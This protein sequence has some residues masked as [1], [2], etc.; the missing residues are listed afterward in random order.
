M[1]LS[2]EA[3]AERY[4]I[5]LQALSEVAKAYHFQGRLDEAFHL[6]Q[7][8]MQLLS[9][10]EVQPTDRVKFL[11][12]Y[13]GF[14]IDN[15]FL[16]NHEEDLML[17]VVQ[18][19]REEAEAAQDQ[20]A[21]ASTLYQVGQTLYY[22]HMQANENDYTDARDYFQQA[23][24]LREK[25][26]DLYGLANS[27]FYT[28]LTYERHEQEEPAVDYYQ[29]A[30]PL[31]EQHGNWRAASE[32]A[33]HLAGLSLSK[34]NEHSLRY[35]LKSLALREEM[36]FN[37]GLPPAQLLVSDVYLTV[38]DLARALD[39]CQQSEQ[40][41]QEMGLQVYLM[42]AKLARG[43]IAYKQGQIAEARGHFEQSAALARELKIAYGVTDA[44]E[45]LEMLAR[46]QADEALPGT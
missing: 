38:G 26:G 7:H 46:A 40:L 10:Q 33:R 34:D 15:Y 25:I 27:L 6:W 12:G 5:S 28:G 35:A 44:N 17:S 4:A 23:S 41:S 20:L 32:A 37:V 19:A 13:G 14:L 29:R 2:T 36:G 9:I 11:L 22:R 39:Y 3:T 45:K 31:A 8:S 18:Q 21:I 42:W 30:L 24:A 16:T 43:E 1:F